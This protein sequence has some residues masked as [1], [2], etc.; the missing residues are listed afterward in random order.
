MHIIAINSYNNNTINH[1]CC[2]KDRSVGVCIFSY[3]GTV[4]WSQ[5]TVNLP[6]YFEVNCYA[7]QI[8]TALFIRKWQRTSTPYTDRLVALSL[9]L[10]LH[11]NLIVLHFQAVVIKKWN[12]FP[13]DGIPISIFQNI[14]TT[15]RYVR[16]GR[17]LLC[18]FV[19]LL[20]TTS[21]FYF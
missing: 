4:C 18:F 15:K 10:P 14:A 2:S 21:P 11:R 17:L 16:I 1:Q 19:S 3:R 5:D 13:E 7:I 6:S 8:D 20:N 9:H 12:H